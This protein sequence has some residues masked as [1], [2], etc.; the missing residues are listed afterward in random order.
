M[1][2]T[3]TAP[4]AKCVTSCARYLE[5]IRKI[6]SSK[7][8]SK[9]SACSD[10]LLFRGQFNPIINRNCLAALRTEA[11]FIKPHLEEEP[12]D[13]DALRRRPIRCQSGQTAQ[14]ATR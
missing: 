2:L 6:R 5:F 1:P 8:A 4:S 14:I 13:F 11:F 12:L 7:V 10:V 9:T 3:L